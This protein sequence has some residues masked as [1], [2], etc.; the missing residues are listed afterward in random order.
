MGYMRHHAIIVTCFDE[1]I[2]SIQSKVKEIFGFK[3]TIQKSKM[4]GYCSL[5]I[6]PDGSKEGWEGSNTGDENREAFKK[7]LGKTNEKYYL[8]WV[9]V[10]YGDDSHDNRII[11]ANDFGEE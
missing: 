10:Q 4:N 7:W 5:F 6:R 2:K 11:D 3:P 1:N 8:D 9:E